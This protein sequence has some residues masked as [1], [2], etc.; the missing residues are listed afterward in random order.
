MPSSEEM[1]Q[2]A[3]KLVNDITWMTGAVNASSDILSELQRAV[4]KHG[5]DK[6]PMN[7]DM[8]RRDAFIIL[9]EEVG[10]VARA[11]TYDGVNRHKLEEELIQVAAMSV[12]M[13]IGI[14]GKANVQ[15]D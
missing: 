10:E 11:L 5:F 3:D 1:Q 2:F 9:S 6:T 13:L 8:D 14:R 12:A 7:P 4:E 15:S